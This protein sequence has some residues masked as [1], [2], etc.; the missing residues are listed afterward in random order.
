MYDHFENIHEMLRKWIF[1][2]KAKNR[3]GIHSPFI[4]SFLDHGL[5]RKDLRGLAPSRRLLL[6]AVDHFR[7]RRA[8]CFQ[9]GNPTV[10][11]LEEERADIQWGAAPFD[12]LIFKSAGSELL[13]VISQSRLW[14]ND[15]VI[16]VENL[17]E[18]LDSHSFWREAA[19]M[20]QVRVILE[21]Y[22]AGLL[23][24]RRQQAPQHFRIRI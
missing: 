17:R 22:T 19:G 9:N 8:H 21:T 10:T 15:S 11:W 14:H 1:R 23:F 3:H 24:F 12:L 7:L 20:D 16:F 13:Q 4:Y 6:A 18:D 2:W 5:Y